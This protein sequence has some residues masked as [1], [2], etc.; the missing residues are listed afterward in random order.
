MNK[1]TM[2]DNFLSSIEIQTDLAQSLSYFA[3]LCALTAER[4][5]FHEDEKE[6]RTMLSEIIS[7]YPAQADKLDWFES[8]LLQAEHGRIM[9]ESGEAIEAI[10]KNQFDSHLPQY[11]G[12]LVEGADTLIR[13]GDSVGKRTNEFGN[14]VVAKMLYNANR[15]YK[16]GKNS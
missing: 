10:R 9:S 12:W 7:E 16:H 13:L 4:S 5:G 11:L 1:F 15:P 6:V 8:Q 3:E 14:I 2:L